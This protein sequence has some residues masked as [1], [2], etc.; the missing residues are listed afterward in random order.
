MTNHPCMGDG[1]ARGR[2]GEAPPRVCTLS[3]YEGFHRPARPH[4]REEL[5]KRREGRAS[6]LP[7]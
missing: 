5:K 7:D 2:G 4:G 1:E 6:D 3:T